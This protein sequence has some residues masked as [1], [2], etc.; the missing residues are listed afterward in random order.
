MRFVRMT[1]TDSDGRTCSFLTFTTASCVWVAAWRGAR[2]VYK[3]DFDCFYINHTNGAVVG[4]WSQN[5]SNDDNLAIVR[6]LRQF[7][8]GYT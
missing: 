8:D 4:S 5:L 3:R 7:G 2:G 1:F 6:V